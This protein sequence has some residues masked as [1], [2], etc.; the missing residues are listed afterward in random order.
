MRRQ[1]VL[2]SLFISIFLLSLF[3]S[4]QKEERSQKIVDR[5]TQEKYNLFE[6]PQICLGCHVEKFS[7]WEKSQMSRGFSG[8]FFQAQ[9]Y[10][11]ALLDAERDERVKGLKKGCL[12]CH[13]PSAFLAGDHPPSPIPSQKTDSF[14][15]KRDEMRLYAQR[16][17]F[18][19]LCHTIEGFEDKVPF[20][21]NY[22]S[23][24]TPGVDPKR[25]DLEFPWSPYHRT[26]RSELH[27]SAEFCGIC[28]NELND[29]G[30]WVKATEMEYKEGPYPARN[31]VCQHCHMPPFS[32]K[33]AKMGPLREENHEHW[34]GGGFEGF[35]E[36]AA[37]VTLFLDESSLK[38]GEE[39]NFRIEVHHLAPGHKF[40]TGA[41]EE[42]DLWLHVGIY[43]EEGRELEQ[44]KIL[45]NPDDPYDMYFITTNEKVAYPTHSR[46]SEPIERDSL[47]E[48]DRIYHSVFLDSDKNITYAQWYA[49]EE[50]ENRLRPLEKRVE[51]YRWQVPERLSGKDVILK[52]VLNYRRMP[53]SYARHLRI[54]T[55]PLIEVGRDER[56]LRIH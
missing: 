15:L 44:I 2:F 28:H 9:Y 30:V 31:I 46:Y 24:P 36:G 1:A 14:W 41:S 35:V 49:T 32:G 45:P 20:N 23:H 34:F 13:S 42:R 12:G 50:I 22:L 3:A 54:Q 17:V 8:D 37:K 29:F 27:E 7:T 43:D 21:H 26:V 52:A 6:N 5:E 11:L 40:P 48:G 4:R 38:V 19:D 39:V 33:P 25:G 55:R 56:V 16:G 10:K 18:C 51:H 53:D 47:P